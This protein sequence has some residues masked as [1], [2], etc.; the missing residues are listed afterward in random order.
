MLAPR[1][2]LIV[3]NPEECA[4][5]AAQIAAL[6]FSVDAEPLT[7]ETLR[8]LRLDPPAAA[9]IDLSHAP[10][11]GRDLAL[12]LRS[13]RGTR[14]VRLVFCGGDPEKIA[15]IRAL[16]PDALFTGWDAI[17]AAL[18]EAL[19]APLAPPSAPVS[20]F[21]GYSG[22]PLVKKLGIRP[23]MALAG[24]GAPEGFRALLGPLPDGAHWVDAPGEPAELL[25]WFTRSLEELTDRIEEMKR[26]TAWTGLWILWPK[27]TSALASDL[28]ERLV[29]ETGLAAGLVDYKIAAV[30][31][32]WSGLKFARRKERAGG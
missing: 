4:A 18:E 9:V 10:T 3:W 5:R 32:T 7:P 26:T 11:Q 27:K 28:N 31:E 20:V 17:G 30:D 29:R 15:G 6:G 8:T 13:A 19:N 22:T 23:G 2:R 16:L 24:Y 21:A 25:L 12:N 14:A 1:I